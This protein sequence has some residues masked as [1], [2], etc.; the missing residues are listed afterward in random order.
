M[1]RRAFVLNVGITGIGIPV[2]LT[3]CGRLPGPDKDTEKQFH[4]DD[5]QLNEITVDQLQ[6]MFREGKMTV[7]AATQ[8]YLDRIAQLDHAGPSL[9]SVI[10][11]NPDA[12]SIADAMDAEIKTGKYRGKLHGIPVL[13]KDNIDTADKMMNTAGSLALEGNYPKEDAYII[14]RLRESGAVL[15]G[16]TNL[17]EWA[18]FRSDQ[19]SSGWSSRGGQTLNPYLL[20]RN[21]CGSSSGSGSAVSANLCAV[22]I[23]TETNGSI[24]CPSSVSG[25]VGI[26]PTVGL[27]SRS[28]IIPISRTQ[29]TAGPMARTVSD[30]A[31]MLSALVGKDENDPVTQSIDGKFQNDY[32]VFL[33]RNGLNGKRLGVEKSYLKRIPAVDELYSKNLDLLRSAG[34]ELV[35]VDFLEQMKGIGKDEFT[36][37]LYEFKDGLNKYLAG[38]AGGK[39][40]SLEELINYNKEHAAVMMPFFTQD[41]LE[42][43]QQT[44]GLESQ[45]YKDALKNILNISRN[46]IN[47]I[48]DKFKLDAI[49]GPSYGPAW[50]T[51]HIN[52]DYSTGYGFSGPAAMAG[53]PHITVPMGFVSG[54]PIGLSFFG[55]AF[56][57]A[58]L[59]TIAYG[60][61]QKSGAREMP[62]CRVEEGVGIDAVSN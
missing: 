57:E 27:W 1:K 37:L 12:L 5:F 8:L 61:E 22:A 2:F 6:S 40:K 24:I 7:R 28:G 30:A 50:C 47:G 15:L 41:I 53:Y 31:I 21:P 42:Q 13:V 9:R 14:R 38:A 18:N 34:A 55:K 54:L 60:F 51:D 32:T 4:P 62:Q 19:S 35:E 43:S 49:I 52:G 26:K 45:A 29:D 10:Q 11:I 39:V 44:D 23:G 36:V 20:N 3:S 58:S 16:K 48:M 33:D 46:A 17:S 25:V 59:L 56:S